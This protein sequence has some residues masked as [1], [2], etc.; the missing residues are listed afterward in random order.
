MLLVLLA[1]DMG[2]RIFLPENEA[3]ETHG[4][5]NIFTVLAIVLHLLGCGGKN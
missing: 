4:G 3:D 2:Y 5:F 1:T